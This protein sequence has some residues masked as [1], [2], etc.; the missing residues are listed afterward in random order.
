MIFNSFKSI[1]INI[2]QKIRRLLKSGLDIEALNCVNAK[3]KVR[4]V[5]TGENDC[6]RMQT[7]RKQVLN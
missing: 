4:R 2:L 3:K 6:K 7:I 5:Q 1:K